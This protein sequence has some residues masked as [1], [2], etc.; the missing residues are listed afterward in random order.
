MSA[1]QGAELEHNIE[2]TLPASS[3]LTACVLSSEDR[4]CCWQ[5]ELAA[6]HYHMESCPMRDGPLMTELVKQPV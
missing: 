3:E 1:V 2:Q 5:G 6:F 4:G